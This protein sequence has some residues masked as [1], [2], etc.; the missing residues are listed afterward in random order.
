MNNNTIHKGCY[1]W[2]ICLI[3]AFLLFSYELLCSNRPLPPLEKEPDAVREA[4]KA[5]LQKNRDCLMKIIETIKYYNFEMPILYANHGRSG[6]DIWKIYPDGYREGLYDNYKT[7]FESL[8]K[9]LSYG[10]DKLSL[11]EIYS[12]SVITRFYRPGHGIVD[13]W[14]ID[15]FCYSECSF[16]ELRNY[17]YNTKV[18]SK[19]EIP[20]TQDAYFWEIEKN[21]YIFEH[22]CYYQD[23]I[24]GI[25]N[26]VEWTNDNKEYF[27]NRMSDTLDMIVKEFRNLSLEDNSYIYEY[28]GLW[29]I[30]NNGK[31]SFLYPKT[32]MLDSLFSDYHFRLFTFEYK[33]SFIRVNLWSNRLL[34]YYYTKLPQ[35]SLECLIK[36]KVFK[37]KDNWYYE[38]FKSRIM[39]DM[40]RNKKQMSNNNFP[41]K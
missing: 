15:S 2:F 41:N 4:A 25:T 11:C 16:E 10:E 3:M 39:D 23:T 21:W 12:D 38:D 20:D 6:H 13:R 19:E 32:I 37:L 31:G 29:K 26:S 33:S 1:F 17:R 8:L 40:E 27:F 28:D 34:K 24:S 9:I 36:K 22:K 14:L 35:D 7:L 30:Q 5:Y 18:Y